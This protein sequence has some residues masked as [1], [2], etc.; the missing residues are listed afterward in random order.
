MTLLL[1]LACV[2]DRDLLEVPVT[3]L[4]AEAELAPAEGV[5]VHLEEAM[6]SLGALR[7][8]APSELVRFSVI[9]TAR[10]HPGHGSTGGVVGELLGAQTLD[11][12]GEATELGALMLYEGEAAEARLEL[13]PEPAWSLAGTAEVDGELRSFS[14]SLAPDEEVTGVPFEHTVDAE[15]PPSR[16]TLSLDLDHAL[17]FVDWRTPDEDGDAQLTE[18]DGDLLETAHFGLVA[19]PT[20]ALTL[21]D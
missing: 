17:S 6:V 21:E 1:L 15:A 18:L 7:I 12:L 19:T 14:F 2:E 10:A 20:Y 13:L 5:L 8:D 3:A 16:I 11:L 9:R 4:P